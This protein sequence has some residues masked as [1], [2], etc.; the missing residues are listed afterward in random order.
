VDRDAVAGVEHPLVEQPQERVEDGRAAL[1]HLVEEA[2]VGLGQLAGRDPAVLVLLEPGDADRAEQLLGRREPGQQ[3]GE[4][5]AAQP[6][7]HGLHQQALGAARRADQ[8]DV[9]PG[10][11]RRER[12]VHLRVALDQGGRQLGAG[13]GELVPDRVRVGSRH[14][15]VSVGSVEG[16]GEGAPRAAGVRGAI[17][18]PTDAD[19]H[20]GRVQMD[21]LTVN[22]SAARGRAARRRLSDGEPVP[23]PRDWR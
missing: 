16:V 14:R 6:P 17:A 9:L 10:D 18:P 1:E 8:Q 19:G 11:E 20:G 21:R 13:G 5:G 7:H 22:G 4:R 23:H 3:A 12:Q 15:W 2:A